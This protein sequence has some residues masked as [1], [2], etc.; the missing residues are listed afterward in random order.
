LSRVYQESRGHIK[1][2]SFIHW[3][4]EDRSLL[5]EDEAL[6]LDVLLSAHGP[7]SDITAAASTSAQRS[8][9]AGADSSAGGAD[10][11]STLE[12]KEYKMNERWILVRVDRHNERWAEIESKSPGGKLSPQ[13]RLKRGKEKAILGKVIV[14]Y[15]NK[16]LCLVRRGGGPPFIIEELHITEKNPW[17]KKE[18]QVPHFIHRKD[19]EAKKAYE[20]YSFKFHGDSAPVNPVALW[21]LHRDSRECDRV[22]F[23]PSTTES[24]PGEFNMFRGLAIPRE[25]AEPGNIEPW[26]NHVKFVICR[27]DK[28][29]LT[30]VL[31]WG[32]HLLQKLGVKMDFN[33]VMV[34]GQG[35]GKGI[36]VQMIGAILGSAHFIQEINMDNVTGT[37]QS[38]KWK[39]N[40]LGFLDEATF[41]GDKKQAN[42]LKGLTTET[43][44]KHNDREVQLRSK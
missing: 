19:T 16:F 8:P 40:F 23:D 12:E 32:A 14:C 37:F 29:V 39:T 9:V 42:M 41:S 36:F 25:L 10:A 15:M 21:L 20:K 18:E 17:T 30:H 43:T 31:G 6:A 3:L 7:P 33:M 13:D 24:R 4:R 2:G 44:R 27:G 28:T 5:H 26:L 22:T 1:L 11:S 35:A 34:A 38:A